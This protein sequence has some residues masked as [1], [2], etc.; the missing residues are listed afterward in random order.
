MKILL[1]I[2]LSFFSFCAISQKETK[3]IPRKIRRS[4]PLLTAYLT[5]D[6]NLAKDKVESI[7]TWITEN[8]EYDYEQL[9]SEKYFTGVEPKAIL[10]EKKA[11]CTGY[12][13]LMKAMLDEIGVK[14]ETVNGYI[15]NLHWSPGKLPIKEEHAW[16]AMRIDEQWFLADPTWDSGYIG[17]IP[18]N[19]KPYQEKVYKKT[20]FK[21]PKKEKKILAKRAKKEIERKK[22]YDDKPLYTNKIGF[23][24][25]P[26]K[27][28]FMMHPDSFLLTHLPIMPIWQLRDNFISADDF[29]KHTDSLKVQLDNSSTSR[30]EYEVNANDY[31]ETNYLD[32]RIICG[33]EGAKFNKYNPTI[34]ALYYYNYMA[35]INNKDLQKLA[36]GSVFE[37]EPSKYTALNAKNDTIIKYTKMYKDIEKTYYKQDKEFD[38]SQNAISTLKDKE[39]GKLLSK[40][41]KLNEKM[42]ANLE[43]D[44]TSIAANLEK[45]EGIENKIKLNYPQAFEYSEPA[46]FNKKHIQNS[47]DSLDSE[48]TILKNTATQFDS[49]RQKSKFNDIFSNLDYISYL[50]KSNANYIPFNSYST[51]EIQN[52]IDSLITVKANHTNML[53]TDSIPLE[54]ISKELMAH[55]KTIESIISRANS[56]LKTISSGNSEINVPKHEL[57][58][59]AKYVDALQIV[60]EINQKS[61]N[62]NSVVSR[63]VK[64]NTKEFE[65]LIS[66]M[67]DQEKLKLDKFNYIQEETETEHLRDVSLIKKMESDTKK[68]KKEYGKKK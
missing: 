49:L 52:E 44:E 23:I 56:N 63:A 32:Q 58:L 10:K 38:K 68:W 11:I 60:K 14:N 35:L 29:A 2:S 25:A 64:Q 6:K 62:F 39:N 51:T 13:E 50:L 43:K 16:I 9:Q 15:H 3:K 21:N 54:F 5:E 66:Q 18:T 7:Y 47:I 53:Y 20:K 57:H 8:I 36:R 27:E 31:I 12:V 30:H 22:K 1:L 34:K 28:F 17:R 37:I 19:L 41:E 4:I 55:L 46:D 33:D 67:E 24:R 26:K 42:L 65:T 48:I 40:M 61:A 45:I 59:Q